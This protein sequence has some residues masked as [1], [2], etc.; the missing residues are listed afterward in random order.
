MNWTPTIEGPNRA[1][2]GEEPVQIIYLVE[3]TLA[4]ECCIECHLHCWKYQIHTVIKFRRGEAVH[5]REKQYLASLKSKKLINLQ[6]PAGQ[7]LC[8]SAVMFNTGTKLGKG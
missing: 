2:D 1:L 4:Y 3:L 8:S 7:L 5:W 6:T